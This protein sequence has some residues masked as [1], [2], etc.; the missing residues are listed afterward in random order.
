MWRVICQVSVNVTFQ[1]SISVMC[2]CYSYVYYYNFSY[3]MDKILH[4][5][6]FACY[7]ILPKKTF[8]CYFF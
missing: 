7:K 5:F 4:I 8:I 3:F 2:P 6:I 1:A